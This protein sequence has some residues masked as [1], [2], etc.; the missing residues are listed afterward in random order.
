MTEQPKDQELREQP[1]DAEAQP[2]VR[3]ERGSTSQE[4]DQ[5]AAERALEQGDDEDADSVDH[6]GAVGG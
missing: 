4:L 2:Q 3:R 6:G 1:A 5:T